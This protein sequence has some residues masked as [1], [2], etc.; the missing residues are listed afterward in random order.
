MYG[1]NTIAFDAH[2]T[3][4]VFDLEA[5]WGLPTAPEHT[6]TPASVEWSAG[7]TSVS[8]LSGL[9]AEQSQAALGALLPHTIKADVLRRP[10]SRSAH[11]RVHRIG[12]MVVSA[13]GVESAGSVAAE[14]LARARA[15]NQRV[16]GEVGLRAAKVEKP[17]NHRAGNS[18]YERLQEAPKGNKEAQAALDNDGL[19]EVVEMV[20]KSGAVMEVDAHIN[21]YS[22]LEQFGQ[23]T[24]VR[25]KNTLAHYPNQS[26]ALRNNTM[27]EGQNGFLIEEL[28]KD[29]A[30]NGKRLVEFSL[31]LDN[32]KADVLAKYGYYVREA[33]GIIR[34]TTVQPDG[35]SKIV[36]IL[37]G[38]VDQDTLPVYEDEYAKLTAA[39]ENRF[40]I[41]TIQKLYAMFGVQDA[42][43]M[44]T[45]ELLATP[46]L[47]D[48]AFDALDVAQLYDTVASEVLGKEVFMGLTGLRREQGMHRKLTRQDYEAQRQRS[49]EQ[50][51]NMKSIA[52]DVVREVIRRRNEVKTPLEASKLL[53]EVARNHAVTYVVQNDKADV[54]VFGEV[55]RDHIID[56]RQMLAA[57]NLQGAEQA[58]AVA[59]ETA[60]PSGCPTAGERAARDANSAGGGNSAASMGGT[61]SGSKNTSA[62]NKAK[63]RWTRDVCRIGNCP[64]KG[65]DPH[66]PLKTMVGPCKVCYGCQKKFDEGLNPA[67]VYAVRALEL[68]DTVQEF[69]EKFMRDKMDSDSDKKDD[70]AL[71]G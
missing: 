54:H 65:E 40:D 18:I 22:E 12:G 55:A 58:L 56:A 48:D 24:Q 61:G 44:T 53:R 11:E 50:Q 30:L 62:E 31:I 34:V 33:I 51:A 3:P 38:G 15:R 6:L 41:K 9:A 26:L 23:T 8:F 66:A 43:K 29:G 63:W 70:F 64:T 45:T 19:T 27:A 17:P 28:F 35:K 68:V 14:A 32:E 42:E 69:V 2:A 10:E 25:Q 57:G 5:A 47:I 49:L 52:K 67:E 71:V 59:K 60:R 36:S 37:V 13:A 21:E 4:E 46:L 1:P 7:D 16:V 39:L 20:C